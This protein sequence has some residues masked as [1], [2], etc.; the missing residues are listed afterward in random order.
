M[1]N[2]PRDCNPKRQRD[3]KAP[4]CYGRKKSQYGEINSVG[5]EA[6]AIITKALVNRVREASTG[7]KP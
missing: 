2:D 1:W 5:A 6:A 7:A 3:Q 4:Y